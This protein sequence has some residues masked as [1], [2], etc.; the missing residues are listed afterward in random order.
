MYLR[1]LIFVLAIAAAAGTS[2]T[3]PA[4]NGQ[5]LAEAQRITGD[6]FTVATR[7][8]R[9]ANIFAVNRPP[10]AIALQS[11]NAFERSR[12]SAK[13]VV[14]MDSGAGAVN[15]RIPRRRIEAHEFL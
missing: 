14:M 6:R 3:V 1:K 7:T 13:V 12:P 4:Q 2:S 5:V 11:P 8:P 15:A 9:G 10:A